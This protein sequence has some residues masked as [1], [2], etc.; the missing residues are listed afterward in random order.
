LQER[1]EVFWTSKEAIAEYLKKHPK[2]DPDLLWD[3]V[4]EE[5][6]SQSVYLT[7]LEKAKKLAI[8]IVDDDEYRQPRIYVRKYDE[9]SRSWEYAGFW[10]YDDADPN[11]M[12]FESE[13]D[14]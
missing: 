6:F 4:P 14:E 9:A 1:F 7:T 10:E 5:K 3:S 8:K 13:D 11:W 2:L 12:Y